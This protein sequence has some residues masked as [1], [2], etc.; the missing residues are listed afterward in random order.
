IWR[1]RRT[2]KTSLWLSSGDDICIAR[3]SP[4]RRIEPVFKPFRPAGVRKIFRVQIRFILKS[5]L[6]SVKVAGIHKGIAAMWKIHRRI[7]PAVESSRLKASDVGNAKRF[8]AFHAVTF[9]RELFFR[10]LLPFPNPCDIQYGPWPNAQS[11]MRHRSVNA[12]RK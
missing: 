10:N 8:F 4:P 5:P 11:R 12:A 7:A 3:E 2:E 9:P 6:P 1:A